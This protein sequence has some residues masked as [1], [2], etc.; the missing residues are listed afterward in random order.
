MGKTKTMRTYSHLHECECGN[1]W[2]QWNNS[3][4][5]PMFSYNME[6]N[7]AYIESMVRRSIDHSGHFCRPKQKHIATAWSL[8]GARYTLLI[9]LVGEAIRH[10]VFLCVKFIHAGISRD[11]K[12]KCSVVQLFRLPYNAMNMHPHCGTSDVRLLSLFA[13]IIIINTICT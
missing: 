11:P 4:P 10:T 1:H 7:F 13:C 3:K 8:F 12:H 5:F 9:A 2:P 6:S